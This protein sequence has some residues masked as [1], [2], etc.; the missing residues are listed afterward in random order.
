[1]ELLGSEVGWVVGVG[2]EFVAWTYF[3][4]SLYFSKFSDVSRLLVLCLPHDDELYTL[5]LRA[6]VNPSSLNILIE[7][8][9]Q[10]WPER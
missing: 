3:L 4:S 5:K 8:I 10:Q 6:E 7:G 9:L 2:V 1:M